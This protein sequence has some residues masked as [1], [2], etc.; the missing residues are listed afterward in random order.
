MTI[1]ALLCSLT[2]SAHDFEVDGIYYN[3][4]S[5]SD[6]TVEVTYKGLLYDEFCVYTGNVVIPE[7]VSR[8]D[9]IFD[10]WISTNKNNST[11]SQKSYTLKVEAGNILKFDWSVSS[12]KN[13]DWLTIM[14]D[15][16]EII[17]K[18]GTLSGSYEKT[19]TTTGTHTL[20]VKYIKDN[21][22]SS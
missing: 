11:T 16:T 19:F 3:I 6:K 8:T 15:G 18:S 20:I 4:L 13:Y 10:S 12:E 2:A 21:S 9:M 1:A 5:E 7:I 22:S 14:L 17:K